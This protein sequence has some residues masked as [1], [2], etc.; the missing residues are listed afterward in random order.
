[1]KK[2]EIGKKYISSSAYCSTLKEEFMVV[3]KS[4]KF[5]TLASEFGYTKK[6]AIQYEKDGS[7]YAYCGCRI[8]A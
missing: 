4:A 8:C 3:K 1:M 2:F 6:V 7:E 5:V